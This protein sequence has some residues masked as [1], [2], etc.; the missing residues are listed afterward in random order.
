ML[1]HEKNFVCTVQGC[2]RGDKGF[3]TVNDLDRHKKS[4]HYID[5]HKTKSYLCAH[6]DCRGKNKVWP[7]LDNFKQHIG[8]M[9][10]G[11]NEFELVRR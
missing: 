7:R 9:H 11:D 5:S 3:S 10:K 2:K 6:D 8:R 4:V 1:K